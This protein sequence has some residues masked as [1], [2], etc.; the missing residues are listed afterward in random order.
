MQTVLLGCNICFAAKFSLFSQKSADPKKERK[1]FIEWDVSC[2]A[3]QKD[4]LFLDTSFLFT[5]KKD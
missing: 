3:I 2:Q 5:L 4:H 1:L